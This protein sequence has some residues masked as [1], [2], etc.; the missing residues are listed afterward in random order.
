MAIVTNVE[1]GNDGEKAHPTTVRRC[2]AFIVDG[3]DG[4]RYI[5]VDTYGSTSR[6][7]PDQPSQMTQFNEQAAMQF[8]NLIEEA[9]PACV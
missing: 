3:R 5:E 2:V 8:K 4:K 7:T 1:R 9:F 6:M